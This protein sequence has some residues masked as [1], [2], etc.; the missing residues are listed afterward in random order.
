VIGVFESKKKM[1]NNWQSGQGW[2][3]EKVMLTE[4]L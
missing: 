3:E 4:W 1:K 2:G